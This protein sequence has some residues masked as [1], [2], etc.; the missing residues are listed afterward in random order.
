MNALRI[1]FNEDPEMKRNVSAAA[2]REE[3]RFRMHPDLLF[4]VIRA[5]ALD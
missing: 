2:G 1:A 5:C 3:R 4:S